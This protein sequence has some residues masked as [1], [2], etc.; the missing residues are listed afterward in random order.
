[1][2]MRFHLVHCDGL[3]LSLSLSREEKPRCNYHRIS[4]LSF[5]GDKHH[6]R[7]ESIAWLNR[8]LGIAGTRRD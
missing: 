8:L 4:R 2:L 6:S 5:I 7:G 1:M 3:S